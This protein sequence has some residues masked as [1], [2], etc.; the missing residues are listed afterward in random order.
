[1]L[2][3]RRTDRPP[4]DDERLRDM[5]LD[6]L[7]AVQLRNALAHDLEIADGLPTTLVFDYPTIGAMSAFLSAIDRAAVISLSDM[8]ATKRAE[9]FVRTD[10]THMTD[11]EVEALLLERLNR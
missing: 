11:E 1:M 8:P 6:S 10:V 9:D 5:G 2:L 4:G 7:M 3:R